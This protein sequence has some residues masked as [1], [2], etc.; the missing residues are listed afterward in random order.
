MNGPATRTAVGVFAEL[1]CADPRWL[2]AEFDDLILAS[3]G[4]PPM[5][6]RTQHRQRSPP[7]GPA[8]PGRRGPAG[9]PA[10]VRLFAGGQM[11]TGPAAASGRLGAW[12]NP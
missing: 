12:Q 1:A 10:A 9:G 7:A 2:H 4:P 11:I 3:F 5:W 8:G 6:P